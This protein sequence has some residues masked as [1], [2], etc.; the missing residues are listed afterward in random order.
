MVAAA[1]DPAGPDVDPVALCTALE[2]AGRCARASD[3][4]AARHWFA[5]AARVAAENGLTP[6]RVRA[7]HSLGTIRLNDRVDT[8]GLVEARDL[9]E[10]VGMPGTVAAIDIVLAEAELTRSGPGLRWPG[11]PRPPRSAP[12]SGSRGCTTPRRSCSPSRWP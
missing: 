10:S 3:S 12:G 5:R 1:D 4:A 7:L 2:V 11:Q 8:A 6:R 9:A